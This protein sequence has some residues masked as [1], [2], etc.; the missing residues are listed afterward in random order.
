M[1]WGGVVVGRVRGMVSRL[2]GG[3]CFFLLFG[4]VGGRRLGGISVYPILRNE[5]SFF[6]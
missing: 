5:L 2:G 1:V 6:V 4:V 3:S